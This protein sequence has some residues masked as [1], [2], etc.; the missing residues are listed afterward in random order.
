MPDLDPTVTPYRPDLAA[1]HL[2]GAVDAERFADG[3]P[4]QAA[5][6]TVAIRGAPD[7]DAYQTDELLL[8]EEFTVYDV[9]DGWAWGQNLADSYVGYVRADRLTAPCAAPTHKVGALRAFAFAG[10]NLKTAPVDV[11]SLGA[12]IAATDRQGDYI[13]LAGGGWVHDVALAPLESKT[14]DYVA[15]AERFLGVPYLWGGRSSLGLDCSGLIQIIL[16]EA[17]IR[18]ERDANRQEESIGDAVADT[19]DVDFRRGDFV[20]F[21][22]HVGVMTGPTH[23]LHANATSMAV[24]VDPVAAVADR[25]RAAEGVGITRV[26]RLTAT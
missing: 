16:S 13:R 2:R 8:G 10:P 26:R 20:F 25:V 11:L 3:V 23:L 4:H 15:T 17:G 5:F 1:A 7:A 9:R 21:P 14:P 6:G 24:S 12:R 19:G 18:A 22:G